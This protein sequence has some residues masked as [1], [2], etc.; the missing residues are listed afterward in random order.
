[1]L[2]PEDSSDM[3]VS[4]ACRPKLQPNVFTLRLYQS[5]GGLPLTSDNDVGGGRPGLV[6]THGSLKALCPSGGVARHTAPRNA[7]AEA[8]RR[9]A[10][11]CLS[12]SVT[13]TSQIRQLGSGLSPWVLSRR[14]WLRT[15]GWLEGTRRACES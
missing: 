12:D 5:L 6:T 10:W 4:V 8:L 11:S 2:L 7:M 9:P 3:L 1:M 13:P 15:V 14:H